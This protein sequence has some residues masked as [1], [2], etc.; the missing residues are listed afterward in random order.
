MAERRHDGVPSQRRLSLERQRMISW[1]LLTAFAGV[2]I[3]ALVLFFRELLAPQEIGALS[4]PI[5][6]VFAGLAATFNP[7]GLPALPGFLMFLGGGEDDPGV[8]RRSVLSLSTSL[9]AVAVIL[10][11]GLV[12]ALVGLGTKELL[13]PYVRWVQLSVGLFLVVI[14]TAHLLGRT[15]TLPAVGRIIGVGSQ[16]WERS[17]G[18]PTPKGSFTFGA[19]YVFVGFG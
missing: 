2:G 5:V 17:V 15:Q 8:R 16:I 1:V 19:G 4:L 10:P 3:T 11:I 7:C 13:S 9:G 12:V 14:A 18:N 6:A